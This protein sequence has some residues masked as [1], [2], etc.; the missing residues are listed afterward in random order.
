MELIR[1]GCPPG[2]AACSACS[3]FKAKIE[4]PEGEPEGAQRCL[5]VFNADGESRRCPQTP[6]EVT[7]PSYVRPRVTGPA[8]AAPPGA[9]W[10]RRPLTGRGTGVPAG[11]NELV[12]G[13]FTS[14]FP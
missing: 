13:V 11:L 9:R 5:P 12:N 6:Q 4:V 1:T 2:I 10:A 14:N 3:G 8:V 7:Q